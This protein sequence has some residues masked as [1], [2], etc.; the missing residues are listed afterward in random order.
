ML[1][2]LISL[3]LGMISLTTR[4]SHF[5]QSIFQALVGIAILGAGATAWRFFQFHKSIRPGA[6]VDPDS[7]FSDH[8]HAWMAAGVVLPAVGIAMIMVSLSFLRTKSNPPV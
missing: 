2:I 7:W 8:A 5:L 1:L 3:V 6:A 4:K